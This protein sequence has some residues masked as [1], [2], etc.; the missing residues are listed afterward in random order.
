MIAFDFKYIK[1]TTAKE[2][3][4][5]FL[6]AKQKGNKAMFYSGGTEIITLARVNQLQTDM[7]IDIKGIPEC[8]VLE[9]RGNELVIGSTVS[10]NDIA[11]SKLFP[12]LGDTVQRIADHTSRN[13]ITI[14]GNLNS[15][16]IYK[17]GILPLLVAD[18]KVKLAKGLEQRI[19]SLESIFKKQL[20]LETG[21]FLV[22]I[23]VDKSYLDHPHMAKKRTKISKV[24]YPVVSVAALVKECQIQI[25]FSGVCQ[26]PFRSFKLES[27][28]N[29]TKVP[30]MER[31]GTAMQHLPED[32][33]DDIQGTKAYRTFVLRNVL[34]DILEELE[35]TK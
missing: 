35:L 19:V 6:N 21:E 8:N 10:L 22:Q 1:P 9:I 2:A 31:I 24:G 7:V 15:E 4:K 3:S 30:V 20:E 16:L 26:Y 25:A 23:I 11:K 12:L 27:V 29:D 14:G 34:K 17:E 28:L 32:V 18:A 33:V 5:L 13:K